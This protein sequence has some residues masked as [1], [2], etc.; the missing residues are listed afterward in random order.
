[1]QDE[2]VRELPELTRYVPR[3]STG[4][5]Y[6]QAARQPF[7]R[8]GIVALSVAASARNRAINARVIFDATLQTLDNLETTLREIH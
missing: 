5:E 6:L 4:I 8:C 3:L 7:E 2:D 1:M